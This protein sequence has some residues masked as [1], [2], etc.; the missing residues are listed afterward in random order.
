VHRA[1]TEI[2]GLD[3]ERD[4]LRIVYLDLCYEFPYD[5]A[6]ADE[7]ALFRTYAVPSIGTLLDRTGEFVNRAQKR[8]DDTDLILSE[9]LEHGY[10]SPRGRDALRR[11]NGL[12]RR[13]AIT[14]D[15]FLYVLSAFV[16]EPPR[17]LDRFGW[18]VMT[19]VERQALFVFWRTVGRHMDIRDIPR[20]YEEFDTFNRAYEHD[21]FAFTPGGRRVADAT[22]DMF[23][24]WFLPRPLR[25]LGR[26]FLLSLLDDPLLSALRYDPPPRPLKALVEASVRARSAAVARL[27]E[28]HQP[29]L[30]TRMPRRS[31]PAG[32]RIQTLGPP[33]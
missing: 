10:D 27:P 8:Y 4:H 24:A 11:M 6:R 28:R 16:F 1:L 18:R 5:I 15:D 26:P 12:H 30:R 14:N 32:Y 23:L 25:R 31:Y 29:R 19:E 2:S 3:P 20:S 7:L 21:R 33:G 22:I 17:W 9:I 13:F